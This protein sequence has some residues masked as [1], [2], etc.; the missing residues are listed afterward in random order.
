M[1]SDIFWLFT[2][3]NSFHLLGPV[4]YLH[5]HFPVMYCLY[6]VLKEKSEGADGD[7]AVIAQG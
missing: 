1:V 3:T 6:L 5:V 4:N 7:E 2:L